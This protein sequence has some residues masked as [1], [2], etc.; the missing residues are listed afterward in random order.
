MTNLSQ[1][2]EQKRFCQRHFPFPYSQLL[3]YISTSKLVLLYKQQ[4]EK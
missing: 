2:Q 1:N 3:V 4:H